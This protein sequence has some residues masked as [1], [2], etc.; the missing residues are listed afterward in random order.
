MREAEI[1][2][3][4]KTIEVLLAEKSAEETRIGAEAERVRAAVQAEAQKLINEAENVLTEPARAS[5]FKRK[6]LDL[7][8]ANVGQ[9]N[10]RPRLPF[11]IGA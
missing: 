10:N 11:G 6:L 9:A 4:R 3:R 7:E 8:Q 1:A 2:Q 5:L